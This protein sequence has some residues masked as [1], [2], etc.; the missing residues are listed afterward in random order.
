MREILAEHPLDSI[1]PASG[2]EARFERILRVAGEPPLERQVDVGG[3]EWIGRVDFADRALGL[4]VEVDSATY[5]SGEL[6]RDRDVLRDSA[7]SAAGWRLV[8]RIPEEE[9][10][11][12]PWRALALVQAARRDL[13]GA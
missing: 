4:L 11:R 10:W 3:H 5:H 7:L 8:L 6:D 9:V 1:P 12:R 13:R 2:L